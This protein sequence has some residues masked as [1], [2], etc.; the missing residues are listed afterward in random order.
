MSAEIN[1]SRFSKG[2]RVKYRVFKDEHYTETDLQKDTL[3]PKFK[4]A[5]LYTFDNITQEE[6]DFFDSG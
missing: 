3:S 4:H 5:K 2:I 1:K 6:L